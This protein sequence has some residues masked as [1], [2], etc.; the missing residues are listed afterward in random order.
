MDWIICLIIALVLAAGSIAGAIACGKSKYKSGRFFDSTRIL[1]F[2]T[3][4]TAFVLFLPIYTNAFEENNCGIIEKI[5]IDIHNVIR[6]FVVD[7]EFSFV[8]GNMGEVSGWLYYSYSILFAVLFVAA[9]LLT[10][11]FVLSFFKN[12][13]AYRRYAFN[14][15]SDVYVFSELNEKSLALAND[16]SKR[17]GENKK[18][19]FFV[20][21]DV[22]ETQEE[23]N[24]E[25]VEKAKGLGAICFKK[26]ILAINFSFHSKKANIFFF[27]IGEDQSET[28]NQSLKLIE[29]FKYR[30]NTHLYVFS[31][32]TQ[33]ELLLCNAFNKQSDGESAQAIEI[34]VRRVN[35]IRSL[36]NHN[37]YDKG[38]ENIF[39]SA[40]EDIDGVKKINAVVIGMGQ[41][42]TEM[43]KALSWFCQMDGYRVEINS[44]DL[45]EQAESK[46]IAQCP[47]LMDPR[48]ND[49]WDAEGD[50]RYKIKIHSGVNVETTEFYDILASL[51]KATYVFVALGNDELNIA[52]AVNLRS[53]FKRAGYEPKIQAI[54]YNSDK[55]NALF[56][57][58]NFKKQP[59]DI[60]FVGDVENSFSE[61]VIMNSDLEKIALDRHTIWGSESEFWQFDYNYKSSVASA[62]HKKMKLEC[63]IPG[64]DL[65]PEERAE[66]DRI[67]LRVLEHRRWNAYV[68]SEGYVY[69]GTTEKKGRDD[70]A[71]THNCLVPFGDLPLKEQEKDDD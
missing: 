26:D 7:G 5:L 48:F 66:T 49:N 56:G 36:I 62:I 65:P 44:F 11:G 70:M 39:A 10:F 14:F 40:R 38:F 41:H 51:P 50:A 12:I 59:Y 64:A 23:N 52:V 27:A 32:G 19:R 53:A 45:D 6:L 16:L 47:E 4:A 20:F 43:T 2:G 55:K 67:N 46:F 24:Y 61:K 71:K 42:G 30:K 68:R 63:K 57:V 1:F 69:G 33:A 60:D 15:K 22:F 25:L 8:T 18:R 13:S 37:L 29:K 54:V 31:S 28:L 17:A 34:K 21:A 9:P 58:S 3:A 35:E